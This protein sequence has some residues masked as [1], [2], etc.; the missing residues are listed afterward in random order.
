MGPKWWVKRSKSA[1]LVRHA[2]VQPRGIQHIQISDRILAAQKA[3]QIRGE[4]PAGRRP[5]RADGV[6]LIGTHLREL[7]AG[8]NGVVRETGIVLDPADAFLGDRKQQ[9]AVA[10]NA[11]RGIVHLRIVE[12]ES[13]HRIFVLELR[14]LRRLPSASCREIANRTE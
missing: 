7:Q 5:A 9:F 6:E 2:R 14:P 8:A 4:D 3:L 13:D 1:V 11:C 12:T 10:R